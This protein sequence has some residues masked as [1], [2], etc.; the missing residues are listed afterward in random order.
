MTLNHMKEIV[1]D[2]KT[3]RWI[4]YPLFIGMLLMTNYFPAIA[5]G[6]AGICLAIAMYIQGKGIFSLLTN[7]PK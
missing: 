4:A 6:F 2:I 7:L 3:L 1:L 5:L